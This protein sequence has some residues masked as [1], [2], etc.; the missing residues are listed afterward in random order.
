MN[1]ALDVPQAGPDI[2]EEVRT[3]LLIHVE[4]EGPLT[5]KAAHDV[6]G[7]AA[8]CL[9]AIYGCHPVYGSDALLYVGKAAWQTFGRRLQQEW[10]WPFNSDG[11]EIKVH[12]GRLTGEQ[13]APDDDRWAELIDMAEKLLIY[14]HSPAMNSSNINNIPKERLTHVHVLNWGKHRT[15]LPEV[16][17]HRWTSRHSGGALQVWDAGK[18]EE[19]AS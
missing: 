9:Y 16:S 10:W 19:E 12:L 15:L 18:R 3:E 17:G 4:W 13:P 8:Y 11:D 14:A 6:Q 2:S 1:E 7:R 5:L